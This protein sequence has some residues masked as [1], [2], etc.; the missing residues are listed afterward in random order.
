MKKIIIM[1]G[2]NCTAVILEALKNEP[3]FDLSAVVTTADSGGSSGELRKQFGIIPPGDILRAVLALSPFDYSILKKIFRSNRFSDMPKLNNGNQEAGA[4]LGNTFLAL[5]AQYEGDF[6]KAIRALEEAVE[7]KGRVYPVT[8]EPTALAVELSDGTVLKGEG[9][10]D[11]PTYDRSK[12]IVR[13]WFEEEVELN[14]EVKKFLLEAD[15][16]V[17]AGSPYTSVVP[18]LLPTG[19]KEVLAET[20]A[21]LVYVAT[22][23]YEANGETGAESIGELDSVLRDYLPRPLDMFVYNDAELNEIQKNHYEKEQWGLLKLDPENVRAESVVSGNYE[24]PK[25]GMSAGGVKPVLTKFL[26]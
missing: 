24:D 17:M 4:N 22:R 18:T 14:A 8:S 2:G 11:R 10:I 23:G 12:K 16:I 5:A 3:G 7:A 13:A 20:G 19:M 1:G 25:G 21:R 15:Y 9:G 6:V 26:V